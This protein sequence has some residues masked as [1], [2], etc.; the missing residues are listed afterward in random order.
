MD[1]FFWLELIIPI[2]ITGI[3]LAATI[4]LFFGSKVL[5]YK[6]GAFLSLFSLLSLFCLWIYVSREVNSFQC[7]QA[8]GDLAS[9]PK[10][11]DNPANGFRA[12]IQMPLLIIAWIGFSILVFFKLKKV[13]PTRGTLLQNELRTKL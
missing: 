10:F 13:A 3:F 7:F 12:L 5:S 9:D 2:V 6:W 4:R 11:C 1:K 8:Y